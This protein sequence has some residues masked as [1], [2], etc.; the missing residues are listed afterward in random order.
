MPD[1]VNAALLAL[2]RVGVDLDS[3]LDDPGLFPGAAP[4]L[5][6]SGA[7]TLVLVD[8]AGPLRPGM[9]AKL[10]SLTSAGVSQLLER[11]EAGE[12]VT[13]SLGV[14]A[15]D[16]RA[17]VVTLTDAGRAALATLDQVVTNSSK[18]LGR[19]LQAAGAQTGAVLTS[20]PASPIGPPAGAS[21]PVLASLLN[22][23]ILIDASIERVVGDSAALPPTEVRPHLLLQETVRRGEVRLAEIPD[24]IGR[25]RGAAGRLVARL[26]AEGLLARYRSTVAG[27]SVIVIRP[28]DRGT[29]VAAAI[30]SR[31]A[32]DFPRMTT[33]IDQFVAAAQ[34]RITPT[35][36]QTDQEPNP[37]D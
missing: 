25:A 33:E 4:G 13:R 16:R 24:L 8:V 14:V 26:E 7:L 21:S 31:L 3:V 27:R 5:G 17:V 19:A 22:L 29:A 6:L 12:L 10:T 9:I 35:N 2:F 36:N 32:E 15:E 28:T 1:A 23:T 20:V 11:L 30:L 34:A 18:E 37:G